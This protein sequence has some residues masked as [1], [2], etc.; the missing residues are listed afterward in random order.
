[1]VRSVAKP[2][3]PF[4]KGVSGCASVSGR[5]NGSVGLRIGAIGERYGRR[6]TKLG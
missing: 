6:K 4:I 1:M 2:L 3:R 5:E